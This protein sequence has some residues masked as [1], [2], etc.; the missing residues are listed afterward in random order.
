MTIGLKIGAQILEV[1]SQDDVHDGSGNFIWATSFLN[2]FKFPSRQ[3]W[4]W[5]EE[6]VS[7]IPEW[8]LGII[9]LFIVNRKISVKL[10]NFI[11]TFKMETQNGVN[12]LW[13]G[14][15]NVEAGQDSIIKDH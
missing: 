8:T 5:N 2:H 4:H 12:E 11:L 6:L 7:K 9:E 3:I 10:A 14:S 13:T 1:V 15:L